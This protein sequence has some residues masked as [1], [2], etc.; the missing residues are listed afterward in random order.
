[1]GVTIVMSIYTTRL[2]LNYLGVEDYGVFSI[3]AGS[4]AL[5]SVLSGSLSVTSKRF[6]G[7]CLG[8]NDLKK[9]NIVFN[10][11][12]I[13][14]FCMALV[15]GV[16]LE[17]LGLYLFNGFL[18]IPAETT[19]VA[20]YIYH[21]ITFMTII[22]IFSIPFESL[23]V[24]NED[25]KVI[26]LTDFLISS[27][28]L[29]LALYLGY[30]TENI[31]LTFGIFMALIPIG[32]DVIQ[33]FYTAKK[34]PY[35]SISVFKLFDKKSFNEILS[36]SKLMFV[37]SF[38]AAI[39]GKGKD[40][41]VNVFYGPIV[42][43]AQAITAQVSGQLQSLSNVFSNVL[44]PDIIRNEGKNDRIK[45]IEASH[46]GTLLSVYLILI[47][48]IPF[49]IEIDYLFQL[50]LKKIP[51]YTIIFTQLFLIRTVINQL[52]NQLQTSILAMGNVKWYQRMYSLLKLLPIIVTIL[53]FKLGYEA[54][55][56]YI[57]LVA[58][59]I[60]TLILVLYTLKSQ[61]NYE[62]N[63]FVKVVLLP[64]SIIVLASFGAGLFVYSYMDKDLLRL[65]L[66]S[67]VSFLAATTS[68][69]VFGFNSE[70]KQKIYSS[71]K[72]VIK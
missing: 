48:V 65:F 43:A 61:I 44:D 66:V 42:N 60:M 21:V 50:W 31:L 15:I 4:I 28:K 41:V 24:A 34:Y 2:V 51:E 29:L 27:L 53:L 10:N 68:L 67:L 26:A 13:I 57:N 40:L 23:I 58:A 6:I 59:E 33:I 1:M 37:G 17:L 36:F 5:L 49:L 25:M 9:L 35:I 38:A 70:T 69:F 46:M 30:L 63:S 55:Y 62:I 8:R 3:V 7:I 19:E 52:S 54:Y 72:K 56:L 45:M 18:N 20:K 39:N 22:R 47:L 11:C 12:I 71:L 16:L 14:H 32:K 64:V